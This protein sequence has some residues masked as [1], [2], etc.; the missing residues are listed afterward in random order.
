MKWILLANAAATLLMTGV[1]WLVQI[2]HYPLFAGVGAAGF[3]AYEASHS[4]RITYIVAPLM[5]LELF[6]ACLLV[7]QFPAGHMRGLSIAGLGLV[8]LI[9]L[10][11]F[12][13]SVP[14]H[15][16]LSLGFDEAAHRTLVSTNWIRTVAWSLRS[17][18]LMYLLSK[19]MG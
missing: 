13:L 3:A 17:G 11:T 12:F 15:Q 7:L 9:W 4:Q 10:T 1:I 18:L 16:V 14:Q 8:I 19:Q 2:V 5:L 6:T